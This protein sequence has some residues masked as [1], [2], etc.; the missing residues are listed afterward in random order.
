MI[1]QV[2]TRSPKGRPFMTPLWF[3]VDRGALYITTG[4][5]TWAGR[6]VVQHPDVALLFNEGRRGRSD[7]VLRLRGVA[8]CH[9]GLPSWRV[10]LR[11]AVKYYL[12]AGA[13]RVELRNARRWRLR[14]WYYG[15]TEGGFGYLRVVPTAADF[16]PRP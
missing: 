2:A 7:A 13:L 4:P 8:T 12:S 5:Q 9:H 1:V 10:L 11:V 6:N 14:R 3:V 16:V 15:Q